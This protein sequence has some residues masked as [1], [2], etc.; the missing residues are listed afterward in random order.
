MRGRQRGF[1]LV[2]LMVVVAIVSALATLAVYGVRKYV[3]A[4]KSAEPIYMIG[5]IKT[6]QEAWREEFHAYYDVSSSLTSYYPDVPSDTKRHWVN[7]SHS[8]RQKWLFLGVS[9]PNPVQF[10]YISKSG[11]ANT[12]PPGLGTSQPGWPPASTGG[13]PWFL[14]LAVGDLNAN[15]TYS[16]FVGSSFTSEIYA[17]NEGE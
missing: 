8:D 12:L 3:F 5:Q 7:E 9:T 11:D 6:Q 15:G 1:T 13:E 4:S 14:V 10:G 2:E 16:K 17:D